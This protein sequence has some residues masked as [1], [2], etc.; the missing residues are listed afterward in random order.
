MPASAGGAPSASS[1]HPA[2]SPASDVAS[3]PS[4]AVPVPAL[5]PASS[6]PRPVEAA[7]REAFVYDL[8]TRICLFIVVF[9][10]Y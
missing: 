5:S 7:K 9:V 1:A 10:R 4:L 8:V 6:S 2:S 3:A